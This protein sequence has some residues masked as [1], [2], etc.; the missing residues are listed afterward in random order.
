V[1]YFLWAV[2]RLFERGEE[3]FV[4]LIW[5]KVQWVHEMDLIVDGRRGVRHDKKRP[6]NLAAR[7][8]A[9]KGRRI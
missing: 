6:L 5:P 3:R 1:D 7:E 8:S 2:Q 9:K 4:E